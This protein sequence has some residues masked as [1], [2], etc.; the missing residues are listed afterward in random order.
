MLLSELMT[1]AALKVGSTAT[2]GSHLECLATCKTGGF[3]RISLV[4]DDVCH[5]VSDEDFK[6]REYM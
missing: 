3:G 2:V 6:V 1:P 4:R 5:C